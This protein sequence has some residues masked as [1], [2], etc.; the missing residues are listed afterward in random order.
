MLY[1][2]MTMCRAP[3]CYLDMFT[4]YEQSVVAQIATLS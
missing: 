3:F 2:D 1:A 4:V